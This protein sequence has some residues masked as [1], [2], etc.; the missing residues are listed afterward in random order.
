MSGLSIKANI[1]AYTTNAG[2][3]K[4]QGTQIIKNKQDL[5]SSKTELREQLRELDKTKGNNIS[6][7]ANNTKNQTGIT[8][9]LAD[10]KSYIEK[11]RTQ[12]QQ[13]TS[14]NSS[15][16]KLKYQFKGISSRILRSKT[17]MA[18]KQAAGQARREIARLNR[19]K[20]NRKGDS[21]ELEAAIAHAK[22]MERIA[23][24][25]AKHLEEEEMVK[26]QGGACAANAVDK[27]YEEDIRDTKD[28]NSF[29]HENAY[30]YA[31]SCDN[32]Y[33]YA[34]EYADE[35]AYDYA[36]DFAAD[37]VDESMDFISDFTSEFISEFTSEFTSDSLMDMEMIMSADFVDEYMDEMSQAL[38]EMLEETGLEE[39]ADSIMSVD[40]D[41]DPADFKMMKIK[42]RNSEMKELVKADTRYLKAIFDHLSKMEHTGKMPVETGNGHTNIGMPS[43]GMSSSGMHSSGM[44]SSGMHSAGMS[45]AVSGVTPSVP[46]GGDA[47]MIDISV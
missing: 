35:Y 1:S 28:K 5:V 3:Q 30:D 43:M 9:I 22:S 7:N 13:K 23:K 29:A 2:A 33:E 31:D 4:K 32:A 25:K 46:S 21:E 44:H 34:D 10:S 47:P 27:E 17:S 26:T 11:L 37:Y 42:H 40:K 19:D 20:A 16:K 6:G 39:L 15:L 41:M 38:E 45:V 24:K 36:G 12:R 18:A 8:S 14:T